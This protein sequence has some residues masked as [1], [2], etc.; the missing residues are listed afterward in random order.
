[1]SESELMSSLAKEYLKL[2]R[3]NGRKSATA[4]RYNAEVASYRIR[5]W[6][7]NRVLYSALWERA[8]HSGE[9]VSRMVDF[10]V[11]FYLSR[12][13]EVLLRVRRAGRKQSPANIAYWSRRSSARRR[14]YCEVFINYQCRT[15]LN[16]AGHLSYVQT[17]THIPKK[18]LGLAEIRHWNT[19]AA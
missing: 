15:Y 9:S 1:M 3:G 7:V 8:I 14:P 17:C 12:L 16:H 11:R 18:G 5:P 10:A 19:H 4:R 2:W 6:Y 13:L